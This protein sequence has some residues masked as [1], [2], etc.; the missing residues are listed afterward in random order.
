MS[1]DIALEDFEPKMAYWIRKKGYT[2]EIRRHQ[3]HSLYNPARIE[4]GWC[5]YIYI[6]SGHTVTKMFNL[7]KD[8]RNTLANEWHCYNSL[9]VEGIPFHWG[10][11]FFDV[12][13][14]AHGND[15]LYKMGCDYSHY[16][17]DKFKQ[18]EKVHMQILLD[19]QI[20][21]NY[22]ENFENEN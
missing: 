22:M 21:V 17:D 4:Y 15:T 7:L 5:V 19:V 20:L 12:E 6:Y 18:S 11:T 8:E 10:C 2:I 14:D 1:Y 9:I 13:Y 16:E 3:S